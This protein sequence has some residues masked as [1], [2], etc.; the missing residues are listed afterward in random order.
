ME[1][2]FG[3]DFVLEERFAAAPAFLRR[4]ALR[5]VF[6][7]RIAD[8]FVLHGRLAAPKRSVHTFT[9]TPAREKRVRGRQ[10]RSG[11]FSYCRVGNFFSI[12]TRAGEIVNRIA[13]RRTSGG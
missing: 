13:D 10:K 1:E 3:A 2:R 5:V 8:Y 6:E 4:S 12:V 11:N 9:I 7:G